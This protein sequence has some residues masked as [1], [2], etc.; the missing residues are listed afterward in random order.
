MYL[1]LK[2]LKKMNIS[3]KFK[4][5]KLWAAIAGSVIVAISQ[6]LELPDDIAQWVAAIVVSYILG[7]AHVDA[8]KEK[9]K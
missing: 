3:E 9:A 4:S 7:Q 8:V 2:K 5:R 1:T 6:A